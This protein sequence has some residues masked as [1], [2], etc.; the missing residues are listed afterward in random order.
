MK[1]EEA[2]GE[3]NKIPLPSRPARQP[4]SLRQGQR[5]LKHDPPLPCLAWATLASQK[6]TRA[7]DCKEEVKSILEKKKQLRVRQGDAPVRPDP[8]KPS[9][10]TACMS[11]TER[12]NKQSQPGGIRASSN[13]GYRQCSRLTGPRPV[14]YQKREA[15]HKTRDGQWK[16]PSILYDAHF[17]LVRQR[18]ASITLRAGD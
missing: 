4:P 16:S 18:E 8:T 3:R 2:R 7:A 1:E 5:S 13:S 6:R 10:Y 9:T 17:K 11:Q 15:K 12:G 14:Q